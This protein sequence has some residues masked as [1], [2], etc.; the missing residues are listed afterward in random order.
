MY[1][2]GNYTSTA[3]FVGLSSSCY[4]L[5]KQ[6]R[7]FK[8]LRNGTRRRRISPVALQHLSASYLF[9][10]SDAG[11]SCHITEERI[12][13]LDKLG[14]VWLPRQSLSDVEDD[15]SSDDGVTDHS[16][17]EDEET[18]PSNKKKRARRS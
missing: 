18:S 1:E 12:R 2:S 14:F 16:E 8:R 9:L 6:R 10:A 13:L 5:S 7:Q 15:S 3:T 4:S 17:N 11:Q